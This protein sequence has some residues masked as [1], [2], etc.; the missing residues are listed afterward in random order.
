MNSDGN[1]APFMLKPDSEQKFFQIIDEM[2][3]AL[4]LIIDHAIVD[5]GQNSARSEMILDRLEKFNQSV[6]SVISSE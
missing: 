4:E 1:Q 5:L 6:S 2:F 3:S